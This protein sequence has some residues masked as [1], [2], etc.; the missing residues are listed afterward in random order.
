MHYNATQCVDAGLPFHGFVARPRGVEMVER[1]AYTPVDLVP[2]GGGPPRRGYLRSVLA[3][4]DASPQHTAASTRAFFSDRYATS[5]LTAVELPPPGAGAASCTRVALLHQN[6]ASMCWHGFQ[7]LGV[8]SLW[9]AQRLG[10]TADLVEAVR[11]GEKLRLRHRNLAPAEGS[12]DAAV[13]AAAAGRRRCGA[14]R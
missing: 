8:T 3:A 7:P 13:A 14:T 11:G 6:S 12:Y 1:W 4:A 2:R 10:L 5:L 9:L